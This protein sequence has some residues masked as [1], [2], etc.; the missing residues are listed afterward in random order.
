MFKKAALVS[1]LLLTLLTY[2]VQ[3]T[4]NS[5]PLGNVTSESKTAAFFS[6]HQR[7]HLRHLGADVLESDL[8][9]VDL[10]AKLV[11]EFIEHHRGGDALH[12]RP[13]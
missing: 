12:R 1:V 6:P 7:I 3:A 13:S 5:I 4:E 2:P 10:A 8:H 9:F 11:A